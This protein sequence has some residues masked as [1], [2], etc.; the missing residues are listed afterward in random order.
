[1]T[2][3]QASAEDLEI[4]HKIPKNRIDVVTEAADEVF[5]VLDPALGYKARVVSQFLDDAALRVRLRRNALARARLFT[6][7][8]AA[9]LA[10]H[11]FRRCYNEAGTS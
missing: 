6:W 9:E 5:R 11:S 4:V 8:R 7:A 1:M 3:S 10:E 2:V